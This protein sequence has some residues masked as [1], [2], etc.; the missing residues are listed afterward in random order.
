LNRNSKYRDRIIEL[1]SEGKTYLEIVDILKC[2][3]SIVS[4]YSSE[5]QQE[6]ARIARKEYNDTK[7]DN[8][9]KGVIRN[10]Q[11]VNDFLKDKSCVDCG[12]SDIRVLEFDHVRGIKVGHISSAIKNAWNLN[13]LKAEIDKCEIKCCNCHRIAT[14]ERRK[15]KT[16]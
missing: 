8:R 6:N 1:K 16:V 13:K 9:K 5:K 2:S 14:I 15:C 3:K 10:R 11:Y 4:Y 12:N 7:K